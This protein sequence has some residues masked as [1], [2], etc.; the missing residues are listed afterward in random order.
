MKP[1]PILAAILVATLVCFDV[2][3][4]KLEKELS[5]T[6]REM[7]EWKRD[8]EI[9]NRGYEFWKSNA[10]LLGWSL[11]MEKLPNLRMK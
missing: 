9:E 5:R 7:D 10:L 6:R 1:A 8:Y 3:T 11:E 2:K 4:S